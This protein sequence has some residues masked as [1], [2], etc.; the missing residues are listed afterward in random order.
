MRIAA[1]APA[2]KAKTPQ[3]A[4]APWKPAISAAA[5]R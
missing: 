5:G 3:T 4:N 1:I 2:A